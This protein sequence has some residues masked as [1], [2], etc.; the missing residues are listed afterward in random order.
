MLFIAYKVFDQLEAWFML[1]L[2]HGMSM[3]TL[4]VLSEAWIV[5][6]AGDQHRGKI[7]AIYGAVLS[8]SFGAGPALVGWIGIEGWMPFIIATIVVFVWHYSL[9]FGQRTTFTKK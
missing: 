6:Y 1:R 2:V 9:G 8:A 7:V 4:F 5:G 3:S